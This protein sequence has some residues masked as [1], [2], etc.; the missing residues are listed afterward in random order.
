MVKPYFEQLAHQR[1]ETLI[2]IHDAAENIM[3]TGE[4]LTAGAVANA[5][6]IKRNSL[7]RYIDSID[8]LRA[9]VLARH[10]P[11]WIEAVHDAV[12]Q[13]RPVHG[14]RTAS[15]ERTGTGEPGKAS[16]LGEP[17]GSAESAEQRRARAIDAACVFVE[18]NLSQAALSGHG[19]LVSQAVGLRREEVEG[20]SD[21][22]AAMDALLLELVHDACAGG[23]APDPEH[24]KITATIIRGV[25]STG[26]A[27]LDAGRD[28]GVVIAHCT[29]ATRAILTR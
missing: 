1:N 10:F 16:E 17:G 18:A 4:P 8:S 5:V 27:L 9:A 25:M 13:V 22:H 15:G 11:A 2:R 12:A 6:G 19:W 23:E 26:F 29:G 20:G 21:G 14:E 3:A 7:Y 24:A 28:V